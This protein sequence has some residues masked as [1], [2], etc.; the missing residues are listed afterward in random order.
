LPV[1]GENVTNMI[2]TYCGCKNLTGSPVC[3]NKVTNMYCTYSNCTN[4]TGSPIC[5]INVT[6]VYRAY[7]DCPNLASNGYF[8]SANI[9]SVYRCFSNRNTET[10][11]NLYVP[12]NSTTLNTVLINTS[13]SL[14]GTPI[15]W[16]NDI[17]ENRCYY[18]TQYNIYIYPVES[19]EAIYFENE[20]DEILSLS[21]ENDNRYLEII[22]ESIAVKTTW[23]SAATSLSIDNGY[24]FSIS[25]ALNDLENVIIER[26]EVK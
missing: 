17:A 15:T 22:E 18:N 9:S 13:Y 19:V 16:T 5:G 4:L 3:G 1:C 6:N 25:I 20:F 14:L 24:A 21:N 26:M 23:I 2:W 11:L 12:A 10:Y 7:E 8:Y